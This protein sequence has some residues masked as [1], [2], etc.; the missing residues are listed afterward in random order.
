MA[1]LEP[2]DVLHL[3]YTDQGVESAA[4]S[5]L[6]RTAPAPAI[7]LRPAVPEPVPAEPQDAEPLLRP[8]RRALIEKVLR[9]A[10]AAP[11]EGPE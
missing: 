3:G 5:S 2:A 11:P 8:L 4:D 10:F 6:I 1:D 9:E 7:S